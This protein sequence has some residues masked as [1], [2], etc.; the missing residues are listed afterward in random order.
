MSYTLFAC[1]AGSITFLKII[2]ILTL[3]Q[4]KGEGDGGSAL[5]FLYDRGHMT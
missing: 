3:A 2:V 1:R 5:F 4:S